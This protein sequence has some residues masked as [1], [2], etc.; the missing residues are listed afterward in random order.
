MSSFV[1]IKGKLILP[2]EKTDHVKKENLPKIIDTR[3]ISTFLIKSLLQVVLYQSGTFI[4]KHDKYAPFN[5]SKKTCVL[6]GSFQ[7]ATKI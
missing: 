1:F 7:H 5:G 4:L 6:S 3:L 2:L